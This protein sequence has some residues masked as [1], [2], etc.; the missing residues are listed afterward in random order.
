MPVVLGF[1]LAYIATGLW[2]RLPIP[3]QP[4]KA[5]AAVLGELGVPVVLQVPSLQDGEANPPI[6]QSGRCAEGHLLDLRNSP[7]NPSYLALVPPRQRAIMSVTCPSSGNLRLMGASMNGG[8]G[9]S[10]FDA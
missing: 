5:V 10:G 9:P 6:G 7:A 2:Y 1:G 3:V 4:K 8:S